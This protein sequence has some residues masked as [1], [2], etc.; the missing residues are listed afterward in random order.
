M[1]TTVDPS[2]RS[3]HFVRNRLTS[4]GRSERR[5]RFAMLTRGTVETTTGTDVATKLSTMSATTFGTTLVSLLIA[6]P[7]LASEKLELIPDY[8][9]FH[10]F[11]ESSFG[12]LWVMLIAFVVLVFP[13]NE[14][15]FKPIFNSLDQRADRISGARERSTQLH[16]QANSVL[17]RYET[18]IRETRLESEQSRQTQLT[19]AREEQVELTAAARGEAEGELEHARAELARSLEDARTSLRGSAEDL[20]QAAAEQV[21]GRTLS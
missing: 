16:D 21:L 8:G 3:S 14:L 12:S 11:G 4:L 5:T 19:Q 9:L 15:I 1:K 13:L 17:E 18:S 2:S 6:A 20:A 10:F 7:T